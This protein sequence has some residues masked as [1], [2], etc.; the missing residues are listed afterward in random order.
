MVFADEVRCDLGLRGE[1]PRVQRFAQREQGGIAEGPV[2]ESNTLG[3]G[4]VGGGAE[5]RTAAD[6]ILGIVGVACYCCR[7]RWRWIDAP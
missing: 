3:D 1:V 4:G 5:D 2:E 7:W 6:E